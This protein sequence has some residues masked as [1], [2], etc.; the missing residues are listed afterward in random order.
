MAV[1]WLIRASLLVLSPIAANA[2]VT[3]DVATNGVAFGN[4][5]LLSMTSTDS[6]GA[7]NITCSDI[8]GGGKLNITISISMS[9]SATSGTVATRQMAR[10]GGADRLNYNLYINASHTQIWGDSPGINDVTLPML[11]VPNNGSVSTSATIYGSIP[12]GQ[13][14]AAGIYSDSNI[15]TINY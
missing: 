2:M 1:K 14:V 15:L 13:D 3:C 12:A 5:D 9:A 10:S 8:G 7:V 11:H 4:Y 6:M